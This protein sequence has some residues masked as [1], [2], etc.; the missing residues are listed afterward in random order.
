MKINYQIMSESQKNR[1]GKYIPDFEKLIAGATCE[2]EISYIRKVQERSEKWLDKPGCESYAGF[3]F[4]MVYVTRQKCGQVG[5][6]C[7]RPDH[8]GSDGANQPAGL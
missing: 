6:E 8:K 3:A 4:N 5:Y 1:H 2:D 7:T